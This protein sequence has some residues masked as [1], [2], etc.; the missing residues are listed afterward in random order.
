MPDP[1]A[2]L[3]SYFIIRM[4]PDPVRQ[5]FLNVGVGLFDPA[6]GYADLRLIHDYRRLQCL[7]PGLDLEADLPQLESALREQLRQPSERGEPPLLAAA[8]EKFSQ[9]L[10]FT[11]TRAVL[12]ADPTR[13]LERLFQ[14]YAHPP[15]AAAAPA[16]TLSPR[17]QLQARLQA[18]LKSAG[19]LKF[20]EAEF[21]A[22][23]LANTDDNFRFDFHYR[24]NGV[25]QL[26]HAVTRTAESAA[27]KELSFTVTELRAQLQPRQLGLQLTAVTEAPEE[28]AQLWDAEE[29]GT[30]AAR[31][32]KQHEAWLA[33]A[34]IELIAAPALPE[35]GA[36]IR[37]EL[38]L[39]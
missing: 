24:P 13:E 27:I 6:G 3:C 31:R 23:Q 25:H 4:A 38:H 10:Q 35:L 18:G 30:A 34:G 5:E 11:E 9:T 36:R 15:A 8:A 28:A 16:A 37:R 2:N 19:V 32:W 1:V 26:V 39:A 12:T 7:F 22:S 33:Q 14:Q 20:L 29:D 21:R 17:R